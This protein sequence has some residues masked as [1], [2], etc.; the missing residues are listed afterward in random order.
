MLGQQLFTPHVR[1]NLRG[2]SPSPS[3]AD[4]APR[5]YEVSRNSP[6]PPDTRDCMSDHSQIGNE[7]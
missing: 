6:A 4:Q 1:A 5:G 7:K 2:W 3:D